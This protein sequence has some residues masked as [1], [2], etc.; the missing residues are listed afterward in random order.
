MAAKMTSQE[1]VLAALRREEPDRVP[2]LEWSINAQVKETLY[3]GCGK[4][5]FEERCD[6]DGVVVYADYRKDWLNDTTYQDEWG[7][8]L[9]VTEEDYPTGIDFPLKKPEQL[10]TLKIPDP[11]APWRFESLKE[12]VRRYI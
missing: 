7:I 8:T 5:D 10:E 11:C 3:Q 9:A 12:A 2:S 4:F 1:R 6:L